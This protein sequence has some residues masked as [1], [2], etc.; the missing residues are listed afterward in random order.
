MKKEL[1]FHLLSPA[2]SGSL[3]GL[4]PLRH[5][6]PGCDFPQFT[7]PTAKLGRLPHG[8]NYLGILARSGQAGLLP[9]AS[10]HGP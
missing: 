3:G 4:D 6:L 8:L 1:F 7:G 5:G 2:G 9:P 10:P